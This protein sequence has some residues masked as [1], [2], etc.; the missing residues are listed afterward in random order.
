MLTAPRPALSLPAI[1]GV[2]LKAVV[3]QAQPVTAGAFGGLLVL[4]RE[5]ILLVLVVLLIP[6]GILL[7]GTPIA[8][9]LRALIEIAQRF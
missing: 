3:D 9:V 1:T 6:I 2:G 7:V 8:L 5:A 4:G